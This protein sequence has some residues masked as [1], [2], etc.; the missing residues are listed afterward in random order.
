V[1]ARAAAALLPLTALALTGCSKTIDEHDAEGK[2]AA[3]VRKTS[4]AK[5][6]VDCPSGVSSKAGTRFTCTSLV[7]GRPIDIGVEVVSG[8]GRLR[9]TQVRP[10]QVTP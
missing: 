1:T 4:G 2:I 5:L 6:S 7:Q 8:D 3:S 10:R 9:L